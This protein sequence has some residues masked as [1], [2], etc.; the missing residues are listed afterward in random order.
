MLA[1]KLTVPDLETAAR[2]VNESVR[3]LR[4]SG[5]NELKVAFF[6]HCLLEFPELAE[7]SA[8]STDK[9]RKRLAEE[10]SKSCADCAGCTRAGR[11]H[12]IPNGYA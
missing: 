4:D 10:V 9:E 3:I 6:P 11:C 5:V 1:Q 12:G 2:G 7:D 8:A